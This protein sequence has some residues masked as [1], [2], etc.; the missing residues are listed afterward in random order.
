MKY[1]LYGDVAISEKR[2]DFNARIK[3]KPQRRFPYT[4]SLFALMQKLA[5]VPG[6]FRSLLPLTMLTFILLSA[7]NVSAQQLSVDVQ[8][9]DTRSGVFETPNSSFSIS[10]GGPEFG[11]IA[12]QGSTV[13]SVSSQLNRLTVLEK[14]ERVT[15]RQFDDSGNQ[16]YSEELPYADPD[17]ATLKIYT[18]PDGRTVLRESVAYFTFLTPS[19]TT[20]YALSNSSQSLSGER[21][22]ELASDL[23]GITT[24]LYNPA[25]SFGQTTGSR[26]VLVFGEDDTKEFYRNQDHIISFL[27]TDPK[28]KFI[29]LVA[30]NGSASEVRYFDRFGNSL[31]SVPSDE[32]ITGARVTENGKYLTIYTSAMIQVYNVESGERVGSASVQ[33]PVL[34]ATYNEDKNIMIALGGTLEGIRVSNPSVMVVDIERRAIETE[35]IEGNLYTLDL[36]RVNLKGTDG[37]PFQLAGFRENIRIRY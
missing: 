13:W 4:G 18:F 12:L 11:G 7:S 9:P 3:M 31:F 1:S 24:V 6:S 10:E 15:I 17:D 2:V 26:A 34:Y 36:S 29:L 37:G 27:K 20:R 28:G 32:I 30:Q 16:L 23:H 5:E 35:N 19:G 33:Q 21:E 22:S 25:I 14:G 8:Q